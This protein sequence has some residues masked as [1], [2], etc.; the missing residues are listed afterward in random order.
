MS[1]ATK[2]TTADGQPKDPDRFTDW[3]PKTVEVST[4]KPRV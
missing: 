1:K 2:K 3:S 4:V